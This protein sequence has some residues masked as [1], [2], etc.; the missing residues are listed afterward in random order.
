MHNEKVVIMDIEDKKR[1]AEWMG[2]IIE[3]RRVLHK[4][5]DES[6]IIYPNGGYSILKSW[7]PD[8]DR[9]CWPEIWEKIE[10]YPI[11]IENYLRKLDELLALNQLS[12]WQWSAWKWHIAPPYICVKALLEVIKN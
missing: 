12:S 4:S 10:K 2:W 1:I 5:F 9:N 6:F 11:L 7:N 8:T 3:T